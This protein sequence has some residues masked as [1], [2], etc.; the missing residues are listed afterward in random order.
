M[1]EGRAVLPLIAERR[2][3][4]TGV[5]CFILFLTEGAVLDW[6]AVF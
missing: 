3:F 5:V 4:Y 2:R 6:S 1:A